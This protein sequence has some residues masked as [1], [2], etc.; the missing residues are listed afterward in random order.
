MHAVDKLVR[1]LEQ[2]LRSYDAEAAHDLD[3]E[4]LQ[5]AVRTLLGL[6]TTAQRR[7]EIKAIIRRLV[8]SAVGPTDG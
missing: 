2:V 4:R 6:A 7:A 1:D 5:H 8:D 3:V